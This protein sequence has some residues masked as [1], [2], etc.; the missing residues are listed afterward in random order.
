MG[1]YYEGDVCFELKKDSKKVQVL[2]DRSFCKDDKVKSELFNRLNIIL[3]YKVKDEYLEEYDGTDFDSYIC[4]LRVCSKQFRY[5]DTD[6]ITMMLDY[7]EDEMIQYEDCIGWVKDE[8]S[9]FYKVYFTSREKEK[10]YVEELDKRRKLVCSGCEWYHK[11]MYCESISRC[12]ATFKRGV[13][14]GQH[15]IQ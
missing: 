1:N 10:Q 5:N 4:E 9:T 6:A 3:G 13:E 12:E 8:D 14:H 7:L 11:E 15:S 2:R